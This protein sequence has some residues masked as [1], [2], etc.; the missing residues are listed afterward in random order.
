MRARLFL[1]DRS[2]L[3]KTRSPRH[4]RSTTQ[5]AEPTTDGIAHSTGFSDAAFL[6]HVGPKP[7]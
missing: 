5:T 1:A 7:Q 4:G 3:A 6:P 2:E